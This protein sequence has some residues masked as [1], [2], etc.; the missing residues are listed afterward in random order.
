MTITYLIFDLD[1]TLYPCGLSF[2]SEIGGR[3]TDFLVRELDLPHEE[4]NALR[5]QYYQQYGTTLR[6]LVEHHPQVDPL[7]FMAYVHDVD[8]SKHLAPDPAL[9]AML[10]G[11]PAPKIVFTNSSRMHSARVLGQLGITRHFET[12]VDAIAMNYKSKPHPCSYQTLLETI[13][14][15]PA[16]CVF[17]DDQ[18]K[19]LAPA[20]ELGMT[21]ILVGDR[22]D[23]SLPYV[24]HHFELVTQT[25]NLLHT[26]I[27]G[28]GKAG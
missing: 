5:Y 18:P 3:I 19:N 22:G 12:I 10:A 13:A 27:N 16:A 11:L 9:D 20:H 17:L 4:A 26:L 7:A 6:G 2:W 24:D 21:T 23:T 1:E 28:A 14:A 25:G 8:V 15:P